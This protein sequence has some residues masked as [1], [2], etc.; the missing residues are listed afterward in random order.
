[1]EFKEDVPPEP[2]PGSFLHLQVTGEQHQ[3]LTDAGIKHVKYWEHLNSELM[4][5]TG[6]DC[7]G[8]QQQ[9]NEDLGWLQE[10][11]FELK[12]EATFGP[13]AHVREVTCEAAELVPRPFLSPKDFKSFFPKGVS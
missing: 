13:R 7:C 1:M 8:A 12:D 4:G 9:N 11:Y 6:W 2:G 10:G 3:E 5:W